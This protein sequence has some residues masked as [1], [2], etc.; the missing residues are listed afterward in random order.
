M[1]T[2]P[3][4]RLLVAIAIATGAALMGCEPPRPPAGPTTHGEQSSGLSLDVEV[5]SNG[6]VV[7]ALVSILVSRGPTQGVVPL[8]PMD[9][10]LFAVA[11]GKE[12]PFVP[13]HGGYVAQLDTTASRLLIVLVR[14]KERI[15]SV[16]ELP[17]PFRLSAEL[18][19]QDLAITWSPSAAGAPMRIECFGNGKHGAIDVP[20]DRGA[21]KIPFEAM[22]QTPHLRASEGMIVTATRGGGKFGPERPLAAPRAP[23]K[24]TQI[25]EVIAAPAAS[26]KPTLNRVGSQAP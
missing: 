12:I 6:R 1:V 17:P 21:A 13:L 23:A 24:I 3:R 11:G 2:V 19:G 9:K 5:R 14:G 7:Q 10:L 4:S 22:E 20:D 25:R 16:V 18:D 15:E 8:G 26:P